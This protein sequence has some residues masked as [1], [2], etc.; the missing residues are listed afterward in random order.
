[1]VQIIQL[2][3]TDKRL[4]ELV[5]PLVMNPEILKQNYNY[6]F[7]TSEDFVWFVAVDKKKVIGFIPV[8][9]KKKEY[10]INNYYIE[11]NNEDTLK[12]LLEK[13]ISETNTSKELTSVTFMEHSS[14]FKDLGFSEEKICTRY[15][16]MKK[17]R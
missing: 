17:D 7:R 4:Y 10:V 9:E 12:L 16:K 3:G 8:E 13:V 14:L 1:M 6:P 2:Q 5:A 15:V 11:S